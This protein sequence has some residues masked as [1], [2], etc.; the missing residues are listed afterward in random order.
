[1]RPNQVRRT[2]HLDMLAAAVRSDLY[3]REAVR[4][5]RQCDDGSWELDV[6]L[7]PAEM[8]KILGSRG[9]VLGGTARE[10]PRAARRLKIRRRRDGPR[11]WA[12]GRLLECAAAELRLYVRN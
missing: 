5:E 12:T 3:R 11:L 8:A 10:R 1:M 6:E 4:A 7:D 9:V 2:L